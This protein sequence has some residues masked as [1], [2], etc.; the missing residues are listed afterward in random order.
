VHAGK[1]LPCEF[2]FYCVVAFDGKNVGDLPLTPFLSGFLD[3]FLV[4]SVFAYITCKE[5]ER[6]H[7]LGHLSWDEKRG[8]RILIC[9]RSDLN[10]GSSAFRHVV[11][12]SFVQ[13]WEGAGGHRNRN[14]SQPVGAEGC[15]AIVYLICFNCEGLKCCE[16]TR[17]EDDKRKS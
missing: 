11:V 9:L 5:R 15:S 3:T 16:L 1:G 4:D 7:L 10:V 8:C 17:I 6:V 12:P 2:I 14:R 13:E